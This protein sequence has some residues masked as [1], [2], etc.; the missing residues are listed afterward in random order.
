MWT[1]R[2]VGIPFEEAD[3]WQLCQ[4]VYQQELN[5][6]LPGFVDE[7]KDPDDREALER[8]FN[9]ELGKPSVWRAVA[10]GEEQEYDLA[11]IRLSPL[12]THVGVLAGRDHI[13]HSLPK[14]GAALEARSSLRLRGN[15]MGFY[16]YVE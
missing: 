1:N 4:R 9:M 14:V 6:S 12:P 13:L 5:V 10:Q 16:Q 8:I 2:Y 3:C 7:Y 11:L 15:I